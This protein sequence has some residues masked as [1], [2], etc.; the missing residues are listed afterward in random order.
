MQP[1]SSFPESGLPGLSACVFGSALWA[2]SH[3][4]GDSRDMWAKLLCI[5]HIS[6]GLCKGCSVLGCLED[7]SSCWL[8]CIF[9]RLAA[10]LLLWD[11]ACHKHLSPAFLRVPQASA[12]PYIPA[13]PWL[14]AFLPVLHCQHNSYQE[15]FKPE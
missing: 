14:P 2:W 5:C 11:R 3:R 15:D 10:W 6:A 7:Y 12:H 13:V 4:R 1:G 9:Q 8:L